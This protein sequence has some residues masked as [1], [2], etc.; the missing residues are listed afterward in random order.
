MNL[1]KIRHL[2]LPL[3]ILGFVGLAVTFLSPVFTTTNRWALLGL[4]LFYL[5]VSG[6]FWRPLRSGFGL[7]TLAYAAWSLGTVLWS[8][9]P[10]LSAMKPPDSSG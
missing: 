8:E 3:A 2:L 9:V 1:F 10:L 5:L 4:L 6:S 7:L